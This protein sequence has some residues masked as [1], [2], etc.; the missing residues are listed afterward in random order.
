MNN[1]TKQARTDWDAPITRSI[2]WGKYYRPVTVN[3]YGIFPGGV[4]PNTRYGN[5]LAN[6]FDMLSSQMRGNPMAGFHM[7]YQFLEPLIGKFLGS[8]KSV[9]GSPATGKSASFEKRAGEID[10]SKV[11]GLAGLLIGALLGGG[12]YSIRDVI[13]KPELS[14][15]QR[16]NDLIY[17]ATTG[18]VGGAGA[19]VIIRMVTELLS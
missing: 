9:S 6:P 3:R 16:M 17:G 5:Q 8:N 12:Y 1:Q 4:N 11:P 14:K 13:H 10:I 15:Q 7:L 2:E 19:D 18:G